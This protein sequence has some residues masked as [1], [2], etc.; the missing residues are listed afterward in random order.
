MIDGLDY[1]RIAHVLD[2]FKIS[3]EL[4][5]RNA[6]DKDVLFNSNSIEKILMN[7]GTL[8]T[9]QNLKKPIGLYENTYSRIKN[10]CIDGKIY[11]KSNGDVC[12]CRGYN[13]IL[14]NLISDEISE[15]INRLEGAY[16]HEN[17]PA[18]CLKCGVVDICYSCSYIREKFHEK[19]DSKE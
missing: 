6:N 14:G 3:Y 16:L 9:K 11:V 13:Q 2:K 5:L 18:K 7:N 4:M 1:S 12:V 17:L 10:G 8:V 19:F 15:I